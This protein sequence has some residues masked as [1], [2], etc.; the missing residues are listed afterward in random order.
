MAANASHAHGAA[1]NEHGRHVVAQRSSH[2]I[3]LTEPDIVTGEI[4]ALL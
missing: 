4:T 3:P 1:R 2:Y